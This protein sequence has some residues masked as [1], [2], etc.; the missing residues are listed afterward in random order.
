MRLQKDRDIKRV[1]AKGRNVYD[2]LTGIKF[3]ANRLPSS[4]FAIVVGTK[5]AKTAVARNRL[6]RQIRAILSKKEPILVP[7]F[8]VVILT[9]SA[10]IGA[11]ASKIDERLTRVLRQ[12]KLLKNG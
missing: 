3:L 2:D 5:V 6:K 10:A 9:K 4:R 12:A 7:G 8:D 1:F 11:A